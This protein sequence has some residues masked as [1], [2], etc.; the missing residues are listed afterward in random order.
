VNVKAKLGERHLKVYVV[1]SQI[2]HLWKNKFAL[3]R[4][5]TGK[6]NRSGTD[7]Q[8]GVKIQAMVLHIL[9]S[10]PATIW[11]ITEKDLEGR[12]KVA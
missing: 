1:C 3:K 11:A 4:I 7:Q 12:S 9:G 8:L 6:T 5:W 2:N 10:K